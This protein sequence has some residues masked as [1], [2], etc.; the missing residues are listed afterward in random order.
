MS[1]RLGMFRLVGMPGSHEVIFTDPHLI[2]EKIV[3]AGRD[4]RAETSW[5]DGDAVRSPSNRL[6]G[7]GRRI[8]PR[9]GRPKSVPSS[10]DINR[11]LTT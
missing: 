4:Q 6:P 2:A 8:H 3:E 10:N 9:Q 5:G 1:N 7:T 11:G